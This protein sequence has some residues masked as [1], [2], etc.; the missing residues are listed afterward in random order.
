MSQQQNNT[1]FC[2]SPDPDPNS[3]AFEMPAG[4]CDT[5]FHVFPSGHE[6]R[7]V[8]DRSYTPP[9]LEITDFDRVVGALGI[10]R[11]VVVQPSVYAEDN[12][13][14]LE[15]SGAD[16][17]RLRAVVSVRPEVTD[18]ELEAF[19]AAGARGIRVNVVDSGG[20]TFPSIKD[21]L[22]F[23]ERIADMGWHIEFLAHV[24]TFED[25]D[26]VLASSRVP[27]VFGHLG[28]TTATKGLNDPGY[29]RFLAAFEEGQ[30]WVKLTGSY[31]ISTLDRFPYSDVADM[32]RALISANPDRL[33]W[34]SDWPH[35]RHRGIMPNDGSLLEQLADWGCDPA[36]R[37]K[38]LVDN[39]ADL[40]GFP[41]VPL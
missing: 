15:V 1:S 37:R 41:S 26:V 21:A 25:I 2:A 38:I 39:P 35:V 10:E 24:E 5:H 20:M 18:A 40:Y 6:H 30:A 29:Q 7:Y 17:E 36:L 19:H 11:A 4:A 16:P 32:A 9:P 31:R 27:V 3:P 33:I 8:P 14:T 22:K 13:A 34:G 23:T 12:T 28:Y